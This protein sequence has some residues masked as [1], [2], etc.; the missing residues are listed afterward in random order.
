MTSYT[1]EA[2]VPTEMVKA[3]DSRL[4]V[5]TEDLKNYRQ[6]YLP[7]YEKN[8]GADEWEKSRQGVQFI[9]NAVELM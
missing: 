6:S 7:N 1:S 2:Q 3:R 9:A 4:E 5:S 8:E